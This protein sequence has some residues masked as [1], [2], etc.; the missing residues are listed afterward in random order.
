M[1]ALE[2]TQHFPMLGKSANI[3]LRENLL[4]VGN[5]VEDASTALNHLWSF[6]GLTLDRFRQTDGFGFVVSLDTIGD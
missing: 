2:L 3:V 1:H 5:D 4:P 6:A